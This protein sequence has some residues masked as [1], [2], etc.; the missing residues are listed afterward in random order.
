VLDA[1]K[2]LKQEKVHLEVSTLIIPTKN[3]EMSV[4]EELSN[5]V[6]KEL[7]T[8]TPLHLSRFYPLYKLQRLPPTPVSILEKARKTASACGLEHVYIGRVPSHEAWNTFCP[9]C[10]RIIIARMG[11][12]IKDM[13]LD[14]GKCGYCGKPIPGIWT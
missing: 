8:D 1:L 6:K 12:M 5:W 9:Q 2:V 3:D 13:H 10:K 11:Y 14:R 4:V 7:G